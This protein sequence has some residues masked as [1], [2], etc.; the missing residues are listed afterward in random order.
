MVLIL[1][2]GVE[3]EGE[4]E[5]WAGRPRRAGERTKGGYHA[6]HKPVIIAV[7]RK[8]IEEDVELRVKDGG[9]ISPLNAEGEIVLIFLA[10]W[11]YCC[12][13]WRSRTRPTS[14]GSSTATR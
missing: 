10:T 14:S 4:S 11:S 3:V 1:P 6:R 12:R 13:S 9:I 5:G 7:C 8:V 2:V